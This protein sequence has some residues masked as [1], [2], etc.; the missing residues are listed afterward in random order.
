MA[1]T[2]STLTITISK[3]TKEE[4]FKV[5][6]DQDKTVSSLL[7]DIIKN[8]LIENMKTRLENYDKPLL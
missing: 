8:Y 6:K 5:A 7:R 3:E 4:I 1:L 2:D